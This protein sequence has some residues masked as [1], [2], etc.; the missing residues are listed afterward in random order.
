[1]EI[2]NKQEYEYIVA[3]LKSLI[4][5]EKPPEKPEELSFEGIFKKAKAHHVDAMT[6]YAVEQLEKKPEKALYDH[7]AES[8]NKSIFRDMNQSYEISLIKKKLEENKVRFVP[9]KGTILKELYPQSDMR[10]MCDMDFLIDEE[11]KAAVKNILTDLGYQI[12]QYDQGKHDVYFKKPVMNVEVHRSIFSEISSV[13]KFHTL[14][15]RPFDFAEE[16][17]GYC[18]NFE[19]TYFFLHILTHAANHYLHAGI[20]L[21]AFMD[22]WLY[23]SEY[24]SEIDMKRLEEY[25]NKSK[26]KK[27]CMDMIELSQ[28]WFGNKEFDEGLRETA[29]YV[30]EGGAFGSLQSQVSNKIK[31]TGK[32]RYTLSWFFPSFKAL[33]EYHPILNKCPVLYPFVLIW[34]LISRPFVNSKKIIAKF[35]AIIKS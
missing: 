2:K 13:G 32:L 34:R 35:K 1:M 14:F 27:L 31:E 20:G 15:E 16:G 23:Y 30:F 10:Y 21:R 4:N 5:G 3:L 8:R 19:K 29:Q 33:R 12:D 11:S 6:F 9:L 25:L 17:S 18:C 26:H 22:L 7:W 28:M 24:R